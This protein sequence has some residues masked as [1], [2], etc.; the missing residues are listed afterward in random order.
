M[1]VGSALARHHGDD[2]DAHAREPIAS[3]T[4][5][6]LRIAFGLSPFILVWLESAAMAAVFRSFRGAVCGG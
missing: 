3:P 6:L 1:D 2:I 4:D 5:L